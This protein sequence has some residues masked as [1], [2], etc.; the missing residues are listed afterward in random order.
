MDDTNSHIEGNTIM[1]A[2]ES[3]SDSDICE[4]GVVEEYSETNYVHTPEND[5]FGAVINFFFCSIRFLI[6]FFYYRLENKLKSSW[7]RTKV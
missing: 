2:A 6:I 5:E 1:S 7:M 3:E 4:G